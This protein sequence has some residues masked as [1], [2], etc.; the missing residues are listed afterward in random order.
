MTCVSCNG[1]K[2]YT[3]TKIGP[4]MIDCCEGG[5]VSMGECGDEPNW[6]IFLLANHPK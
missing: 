2:K 6:C 3:I 5:V 4:L 1:N